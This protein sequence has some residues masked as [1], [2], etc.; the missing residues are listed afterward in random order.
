MTTWRE[1]LSASAC[2][3]RSHHAAGVCLTG[4][5]ADDAGLSDWA[6][7]LFSHTRAGAREARVISTAW[8]NW[9]ADRVQQDIGRSRVADHPG[10]QLH[11]HHGPRPGESAD[12]L[13]AHRPR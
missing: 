3:R 4:R 9:L 8:G 12:G 2:G 1:A 6:G 10:V 5:E 13:L 7:H 11:L